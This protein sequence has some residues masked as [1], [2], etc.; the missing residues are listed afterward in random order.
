MLQQSFMQKLWTT[1]AAGLAAACLLWAFRHILEEAMWETSDAG[2]R[3]S[4]HG[5]TKIKH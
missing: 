3:E 2:W 5:K 4:L 1:V